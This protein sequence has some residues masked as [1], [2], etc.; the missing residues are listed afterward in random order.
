MSYF[1]HVYI[2]LL[3]LQLMKVVYVITLSTYQENDLI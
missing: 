3:Q 2:Y 1:C